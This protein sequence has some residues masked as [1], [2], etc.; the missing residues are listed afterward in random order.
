VRVL[1]TGASGFIGAPLTAALADAGYQVRAAVRDR[2]RRSFP[3][4]VAIA[5]LPDLAGTVDWAPFVA[6]M[7][8]LVH[9]AGIAHVGP[10]IPDAIYDRVNHLATTALAMAAASTGVRKFVFMSSTRAQAGASADAPL[11]EVAEPH[12]TDAYGRSKLAA[13]AAV[14][15]SGLSYT[16]LRPTLVYGANPKGNLASLIRLA[17]LPVPLP[18]GAFVN[19]RSLLAID[20][21]IAAVRFALED[22]RATTETF[23]VSDPGAISVAE[24]VASLRK[25]AGRKPSLLPI[26]PALLSTLL[27]LIG[28]GDMAQR[29]AGTLI[30]EPTKLLAAGWRPVI[31]TRT[32]ITVM[33][34]AASPWKS[35]TA[36]RSTP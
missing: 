32:A 25:A 35:G 9:L 4:G 5:V 28:K 27:A 31:D 2:P 26:P 3:A 7:D 13:E 20:N 19:R 14:R 15:A 1:I 8:A 24:L 34:Q 10:E 29:L 6:G 11:T 21:L 36:S 30:A 23:L 12:P 16:I 17:A 22:E 18:F 33:V